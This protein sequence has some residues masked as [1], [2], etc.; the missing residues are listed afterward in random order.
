MN[1]TR[2]KWETRYQG[3]DLPWDTGITPPEVQ[4]F[5]ADQPRGALALDLGCGTGTN[6]A[7]L[8]R[9]NERAVGVELALGALLIARRRLENSA[10]FD[11]SLAFVQSD[12]ARLPFTGLNADYILDIGCFHAVPPV[13][14]PLYA[15]GVIDNLRPG[16]YYHLYAADRVE[17]LDGETEGPGRNGFGPNEIVE[18]F[19]PHLTAVEIIAGI[20]DSFPSRW[21]L[22]HKA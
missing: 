6:A 15:G 21:Y 8:A 5:W 17:S 16:G 2:K 20:G 11:G 7:F 22:L 4:T 13:D 9:H 19:A 10:F 12:V 18:L 1:E 14:R 3:D